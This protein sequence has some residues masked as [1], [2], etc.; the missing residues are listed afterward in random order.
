MPVEVIDESA[1]PE[2]GLPSRDAASQAPAGISEAQSPLAV[3]AESIA[4]AILACVGRADAELSV[5]LVGDD[6]MRELNRD[7]RGKD[8]TTDVLSFSQLE[9]ESPPGHPGIPCDESGSTGGASAMLGDVVISVPV[10]ERQA[11]DGGWAVIEEL[12]R[13]LLHGV[14]HLIGFDHESAEDARTMR[15]E[16]GRIVAELAEL[17]IPCAWEGDA[18]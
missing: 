1:A 2:A 18:A 10:L 13:L 3:S 15:A 9:G 8:A 6:R 7:W 17:G 12:A 14:L 16:E 5:A 4:T 11:A